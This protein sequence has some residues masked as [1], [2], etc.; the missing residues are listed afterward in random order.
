MTVAVIA[1]KPSVAR[2]IAEVLG[3]RSRGQGSL[4]G[5]GYVVTW[6]VGH[7]A[8]LAQPHEI[9]PRWKRWNLNELPMIPHAWPVRVYDKTRDQFDVVQQI[10]CAPDTERIVCATDAGRE[11]E[12]IFRFIYEAAG[13][14]KP[15]QRLWISSLTNQAIEQGF[16]NLRPGSDFDGL[17]DAARG[18]SQADWL[19]GMNL[20]RFYTLH[21]SNSREVLSVGRV[22]TPTLAMVVER[23]LAIRNF[24]SEDYKE[25]SAI[26]RP[27]LDSGTS[28]PKAPTY[29]GLYCGGADEPAVPKPKSPKKESEGDSA[30]RATRLPAD[31]EQAAA[32]AARALAGNAN[33]TSIEGRQRK[34][35]PPLLYDLT[36]LQRHANRLY[37]NSAKKTLDVAQTLYE[38]KFLS[39]PRTDSRAL[40]EDMAQTLPE[41]V[42][43]IREPFN[44]LLAAG[45]GSRPLG[46]RFIDDSKVGDHHALIP[47]ANRVGP[48]SLTRD[49][50]RIYDLVCRR[51]LAAWHQDHLYST[52]TVTTEITQPENAAVDSGVVDRY[53]STGTKVDQQGWRMLEAPHPSTEARGGTPARSAPAHAD[54][55]LPTALRKNQ[56]QDVLE[57]HVDDKAT[58]PPRRFTEATLLTAMETAGK[59]VDDKEL[60]QA[61]RECGLGTPAT[62]AGTIETLLARE[63]IK[64]DKKALLATDKGIR[65]I[66]LVHPHAKSPAMTGQWEAELQRIQDGKG[67]LNKFTAEIEAFV[68]DVVASDQ[69]PPPRPSPKRPT[70]QQSVDTR[71]GAGHGQAPA[72]S[73][74]PSH[75]AMPSRAI[76]PE[77]PKLA[78]MAQKPTSPDNLGKL[79]ST[80]FG[81]DAFRPHQE[82]ACR[83][84]CSGEDVLLVMP[85][86]AG[87]SLCYQLPGIARAGTT[88]VVSPLIALMEDQVIKLQQQGFAAERIHS[89]RSREQ[90]REVCRDYL[91][92]NLDFLFI[93]PERLSVPG[94]P[95][96]LGKRKP[97]LIAIDEAHCISQWGHDFRPDYRML[98]ERLPL[99]RPAPIVALTA[100][101]T[102][103]VQ[104]DI[105]EQLAVPKAHRFI[106]GF[107]RD[108][109]AIEVVEMKPSLRNDNTQRLLSL[110]ERTPAI[111]YAPTRK[112]AEQLADELGEAF[113]TAAYHAGMTPDRRDKVQSAFLSGALDV[114][115]ATVAFGMGIDKANV[116]TVVHLAL[117][118]SVENYYQEIGRSGRD[119]K[120]ARAFLL[121]GFIDRRTHEWF[122]ERD[123]PDI[124]LLTK[125]FSLLSDK[126]ISRDQL[127]KKAKMDGDTFE[128]ALE[129]LWI[130]GGAI[131]T[132]NEFA[133]RGPDVW[134]EPYCAQIEH[135]RGQLEEM[136]RFADSHS[137]RMQR[138][139]RHFGDQADSGEPCG[140][141][142][143]CAPNETLAQESIEATSRQIEAME[144]IL[145]TLAADRAP[146]S[147]RLHSELFGTKLDRDEFEILLAAL[148]RAGFVDIE[149]DQFE[150]DGRKIEFQRPVI[151]TS[152]RRAKAGDVAN[153]RIPSSGKSGQSKKRR[154]PRKKSGARSKA[155]PKARTRKSASPTRAAGDSP[156][157]LAQELRALRLSEAERRGIPA[158]RI[159]NDKVLQALSDAMP[160]TSDELMEV[161]GVGPALTKKYGSRI[162][163]VVAGA[164]KK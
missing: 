43:T 9:Q 5:N 74:P 131:V 44:D 87:K 18:R 117:P 36:E 70:G 54:Q 21:Q 164:S 133:T 107:R 140:Q 6:A 23:E 125:L 47:T 92:G 86:G 42:D 126:P 145:K 110:K 40:T 128:K 73:R 143:I 38:K 27:Q 152:G 123:Y 81:F 4:S 24:V 29:Q 144:R 52:T 113:P 67:T 136:A 58:R 101:A 68:R 51:L 76:R 148:H 34:I 157:V 71:T 130:H 33:V 57:S 20:S 124:K 104:N 132:P 61:M 127:Q 65:L 12:L 62:R 31:G 69:Q 3:A 134:R 32:I 121:H 108:N 80:R 114:I 77:P 45:T 2:D 102:P 50:A 139:V 153:V 17:A 8:S 90:S 10:L 122:F 161:K 79:L 16:A 162:L 95:E 135:R 94:F 158:F 49:E 56:P 149:E 99:F 28:N 115:V 59:T 106:H 1:E 150:S 138:L 96:M 37:G 163:R 142:D 129:K 91:S 137:C 111:V 109:I 53:R 25:V 63:Y 154:S 85:T 39:Y 146:S 60:S 7:L 30:S 55:E 160:A 151:T 103:R 93:A 155:S 82:Q 48:T 141:C 116:R 15:V 119:G 118:A 159:F 98:N 78:R 22:Q 100:T 156:S 88:L 14:D 46:R 19:V 66:E 75:S 97:T 83:T 84:I 35:P 41:V 120:P 72:V 26:F 64:R 112:K 89:G 147:G 13:A 105:I 11:G